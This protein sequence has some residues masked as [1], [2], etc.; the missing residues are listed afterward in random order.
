MPAIRQILQVDGIPVIRLDSAHL[1]VDVAPRVG[2]RVTSIVD[3]K[4]RYEFLWHNKN[5]PLELKSA[6]SEYDPNFYGGIDE[7]LPNDLPECIDGIDCPD[8]GELWTTPL[9]AD[10]SEDRLTLRVHLPKAGLAYER[11]MHIRQNTSWLDFKYRLTNTTNQPRQLL[12]K[13]HAALAVQA[14][15]VIDCPARQARI[16]APA[17]SRFTTTAPFAWPKIEDRAANIVPPLD[18]TMDFFYLSDLT[19]GEMFWHRPGAGL[20]FGYK[21]DSN[22]FPYAWLFASYGGFLGHYTII[23]EPCTCMPMSVNEAAAK[24]QCSRLNPGQVLE[25]NVS[26]YAGPA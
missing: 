11:E 16:V 2:G 15:D 22:V 13:L 5:L 23:L 18:G 6:G 25:T 7:L 21:F 20:K 14:G 12:W 10:I 3:K 9:S 26:L 4:S 19:A 1:Q 8:H 17:W 24:Q